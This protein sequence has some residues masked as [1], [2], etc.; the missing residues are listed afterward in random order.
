MS[1]LYLTTAT[2]EVP[3]ETEVPFNGGISQTNFNTLQGGGEFAFIN[4]MKQ[5]GRWG[6]VTS[7]TVDAVTPDLF[8]NDGYP[9]AS[10]KFTTHGGVGTIV[11]LP[12]ELSALGDWIVDWSGSGTIQL[13]LGTGSGSITTV[14]GSGTSSPWRVT[15][16]STITALAV[17]ITV[18][19]PTNLRLYHISEQERLDN[20]E[21]F[22]AKFLERLVEGNFGV[23]RFLNWQDGNRSQVSTWNYGNRP[24]SYF[25]YALSQLRADLLC[26]HAGSGITTNSGADYAVSAPSAWTGLVDK[27]TVH[28][29]WNAN[30]PTSATVTF[31]GGGSPNITWTAHGLAANNQ[32]YFTTTGAL[33]AG[34]TATVLNVLPS[35]LYFVTVIDANTVNVSATSGGTVINFATSG[36]GTTTGRTNVTLNVGGTGAKQVISEYANHLTSS[37]N[38]FP[39]GTGG[40]ASLSTLVYDALLNAWI[41]QGGSGSSSGL[42][43]GVPI[44]VCLRLCKE[45]GAHPWFL[46]PPLTCTPMSDW[47]TQLATLCRDTMPTWMTPYIEPPNELW[48]TAGAFYNTTYAYAVSQMYGWGATDAVNWYGRALSTIGQA[49][50]A[51]YGGAVDGTK[52]KIVCGIQAASAANPSSND[53]RL[54]STKYLLQTP[55]PGY[56]ATQAAG[57]CTNVCLGHY[58]VPGTFGYIQELKLAGQYYVTNA[59]NP[60]GQAAV[61]ATYAAQLLGGGITTVSAATFTLN[62]HGFVAIQPV[63]AMIIFGGT[64][65][66]PLSTA[67]QYFVRSTNLTANTF[68]LSTTEG[69]SAVS[70][71]GGSG[72]FYIVPGPG[73]NNPT[74]VGQD[75][76]YKNTAIW[77]AGIAGANAITEIDTYEGGLASGGGYLSSSVTGVVTGA[78]NANPM[79]LTLSTTS[80]Q[81]IRAASQLN[82]NNESLVAGVYLTLSGFT[83]PN[84]TSLNGTTV[85]VNAVSGA[86]ITTNHNASARAANLASGTATATYVLNSSGTTTYHV[87][88]TALRYALKNAPLSQD[89]LTADYNNLVGTTSGAISGGRPGLYKLGGTRTPFYQTDVPS[90]NWWSILETIYTTDD[91]PQWKAIKAFNA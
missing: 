12:V 86:T 26:N 34:I 16:A 64:L 46:S 27:T 37:G 44:S 11:S 61:A 21:M 51:V 36:T 87:A 84:W 85:L 38:G 23:L 35:N 42:S 59:G 9:I 41:K 70:C 74:V 66:S 83:D 6:W 71:T 1:I 31:A 5:G 8:D 81:G 43:N 40:D 3:D 57:W 68:E 69:G 62:S 58:I 2:L 47:H 90:D 78:T 77:A 24:E 22:S 33:P 52:Y 32:I 63:A 65:P 67:T 17:R 75:V 20:G 45:V 79:V 76:L 49:V 48:N 30:S 88:L 73:Q 72:T 19:G 53:A 54:K 80:N 15:L 55:Q 91:P 14:S 50:N 39:L 29:V 25:Q 10:A 60:T 28:V 89:Y 18:A 13:A 4:Q 82:S 56:T 7:G